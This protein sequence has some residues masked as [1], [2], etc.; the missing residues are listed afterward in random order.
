MSGDFPS[1][2]KLDQFEEYC[3]T[4]IFLLYKIPRDSGIEKRFFNCLLFR[5]AL[6]S[7][8]IYKLRYYAQK[9][10]E[11]WLETNSIFYWRPSTR[12]ERELPNDPSSLLGLICCYGVRRL[13]AAEYEPKHHHFMKVL[14]IA[15]TV[16]SLRNA[17]YG[18]IPRLMIED[19]WYTTNRR[20][21]ITFED[22]LPKIVTL[23][24]RLSL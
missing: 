8:P 5:E 3:K 4:K 12:E 9:V 16:K 15:F 10:E 11:Y 24:S 20:E 21:T 22:I 19:S 14:R 17:L 13:P 2:Q 1:R 18:H 7:I 23:V 6:Y